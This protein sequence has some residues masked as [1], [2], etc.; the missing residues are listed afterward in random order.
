MSKDKVAILISGGIDSPVAAYML[1]RSGFD[2]M[3]V[4][5]DN[6]PFNDDNQFLKAPNLIAKLEAATGQKIPLWVAPH[7]PNQVQF[8]RKAD[9]HMQ[10]I[11]CRRMMWSVA[12]D[13]A[14]AEGCQFIATGESLGQVASQTLQNIRSENEAP[15]LPMLRPLIGMDKIEIEA[16]AKRIGTYE[17]STGPGVCCT[18]VPD[19]PVTNATLL[20]TDAEAAKVDFAGMRARAVEEASLFVIQGN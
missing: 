20:R 11:L 12:A 16:V 15:C 19:K 2:L 1:A 18:I 5:M 3:A 14:K 4:N 13:I 17:I 7:G 6:R 8:A 9:R 10:C